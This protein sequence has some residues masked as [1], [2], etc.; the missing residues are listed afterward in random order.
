MTV[1]ATPIFP[2]TIN[3]TFVQILPADTTTKKT[4]YTGGTNGSKIENICIT[5]TDTGAY[6]LNVYITAS[7]TDYLIGTVSVPLSA[8]NTTAAP[9]INLLAL[10]NFLPCNFDAFGNKYMYL[11]SGSVLKVASTTT[12]TTAKAVTVYCQGGDF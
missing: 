6:T 7:A 12:V 10:A 9:S 2:Q 11:A 3:N 8:G 5:N 1:T 4:I